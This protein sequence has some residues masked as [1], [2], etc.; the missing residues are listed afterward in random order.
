[1]ILESI[2]Q[3]SKLTPDEKFV[4]ASELC[5]QAICEESG[6]PSISDE[7][8][9]ELQQSLA[10]YRKEPEQGVCWEELHNRLL[11]SRNHA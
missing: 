5:Q 10:E 9:K 6:E 1:M 2:P 11:S 8:A 7:L 3:L 4:L